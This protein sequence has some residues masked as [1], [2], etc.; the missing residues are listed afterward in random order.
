[1][2]L[3]KIGIVGTGYIAKGLVLALE[4][5][6]EVVVSK[7]L[8]R[9]KTSEC[10]DFP[11][12]ELLTNNVDELIE[13]ADLIVECSGDV[14]HGTD[15][16]D[17]CIRASL[18]IVTMNSELHVTTG[19]YFVKKGF[20]TEAEGDQP[21]CLA[22]LKEEALEMGFKPLVY[23]NVKGFLNHNPSLK[24]MQYW[25]K[26]S[27]MSLQMVTS[28]TDGTK[29]EIEQALVANG[30]NAGIAG[31]GLL[32]M[33]VEDIYSGAT[34]LADKAKELGYPISDYILSAKP[35]PAVFITAEHDE[36]QRKALMN[37][38]M[39]E[40]PYY[41]LFGYHHLC[42]LEIYKTIKRV[43]YGGGVLLNNGEFPK[44]SVAAIAKRKLKPGQLIVNGI[45]SFEV[46]GKACK[47]ADNPSHVPIGL[48][49]NVVVKRP[50]EPGQPLH[51]DD[52]EIPDSLALRVWQDIEKKAREKPTI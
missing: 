50:I 12:K 39:G 43:L 26:K 51:F 34:F 35:S 10:T 44:I 47:I 29:V 40:G 16:I 17:K 22:K 24:E 5:K 7:V 6:H 49:K 31:D 11:K 4:N 14:I 1:M 28:F 48:L 38:K 13:H 15:M 41:T 23:G 9:R 30:L 45:G 27:G 20:I 33:D 52:I 3:K 37:Y 36:N 21:G 46:R 25:S 18:P 32:G 19:S 2:D 8:T 42:Y